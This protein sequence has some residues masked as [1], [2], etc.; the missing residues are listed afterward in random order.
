MQYSA[1]LSFNDD[2]LAVIQRQAVAVGC[3]PAQYEL[4]SEREHRTLELP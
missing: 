4:V 1:P 3:K 2:A